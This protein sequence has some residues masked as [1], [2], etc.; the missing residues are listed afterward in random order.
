MDPDFILEQPED[1][2]ASE[3]G[4]LH[5]LLYQLRSLDR[6][7]MD[8][9]MASAKKENRI[10]PTGKSFTNISETGLLALLKKR[11]EAKILI[12]IASLD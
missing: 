11:E 8:F 6:T 12:D 7:Q 2:N 5:K 10:N 1:I 9:I 4:D 3:A